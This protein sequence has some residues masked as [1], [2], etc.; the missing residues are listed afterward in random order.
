[1]KYNSHAGQGHKVSVPMLISKLPYFVKYSPR[2]TSGL[3]LT[4]NQGKFGGVTCSL[5]SHVTPYFYGNL[6]TEIWWG[7]FHFHCSVVSF[8]LFCWLVVVSLFQ[9]STCPLMSIG[10]RINVI[11]IGNCVNVI[12]INN[13][14]SE[15]HLKV[16][17]KLQ[18]YSLKANAIWK[19]F[20]I[21]CEFSFMI[22]HLHVLSD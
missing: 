14:H 17:S 20:Q 21:A 6:V 4:I 5:L 7:F 22:T 10:N 1:M 11:S 2:R 19:N 15:W 18:A 9:A 12:P 13:L 3:Y 16:L 8:W